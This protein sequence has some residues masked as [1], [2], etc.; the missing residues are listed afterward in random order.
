MKVS[1]DHLVGKREQR[2]GNC[3]TKRLRRFKV[4]NEFELGRLPNREIGRFGALENA[5]NV[6]AAMLDGA[7]QAIAIAH[8]AASVGKTAPRVNRGDCVTGGQ[9][10]KLI[11][12][13]VEQHVGGDK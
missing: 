3:D 13:N 9:V 6:G 7:A 12:L 10:D 2:R 1:L 5:T 4:D 11:A 8:Q